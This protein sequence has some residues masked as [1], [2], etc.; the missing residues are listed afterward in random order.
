MKRRLALLVLAVLAAL[1]AYIGYAFHGIAKPYALDSAKQEFSL[2]SWSDYRE[3][4]S[5][6]ALPIIIQTEADRGAL[7]FFGA[8]H[9]NDPSHPQFAELEEAFARFDPTVVVVEGR[10]GP[11]LVPFMDPIE[12][13]GES[14]ALVQLARQSGSTTYIWE[15]ERDDEV[16]LLLDRFS[17]EQVAIYLLMRPFPGGNS[18][19]EAEAT[20]SAIIEDRKG[21]S[22]IQGV[23]GSLEQFDAAW[24]RN[25]ASGEDWRALNGVYG[26]PGFLGEMFEYG[27]DIRDQH[28]LNI[29]RELM[30]QDERVMVTMGWSHAVRVEP[31]LTQLSR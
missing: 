30:E 15:L 8:E 22:G 17:E 23:I 29:V 1:A 6:F 18:A 14:G 27:N 5:E 4:A 16:A 20:L 19:A 31:A 28:M 11:L 12:T 13:Y 7:L 3:R 25:L 26:A 21:R 24:D 9:S 10:P 2:L